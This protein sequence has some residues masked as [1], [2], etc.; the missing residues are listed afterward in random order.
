MNMEVQLA[1]DHPIGLR[2]KNPVM[3]ASGTFGFGNEYAK[4]LEVAK[5]GAIVTK[6]VTLRPRRGNAQPR[7]VET[8]AG[9]L[10][11]I[12]LQNPGAEAVIAQK[13]SMWARLDLPVIVNIAGETV[14]EYAELAEMFDS[15]AGV[16][17]LEV[18]VSCP[19]VKVGAMAFGV[20]PKAAAEVTSAVKAAT[21]MP[22]IVK[23]SPNVTDIVEI[24]QA[25]VEAGADAVSLINTLLG[26]VIDIRARR[27]LLSTVTGGLSGPAIRPVALRMVYQVAR[28]VAVPIIGV[29]GITSTEDALQFLMAGASAVQ[30][31]TATFV[32]PTT[33]TD[34]V[35]GLAAFLEAEGLSSIADIIG[36]AN[37]RPTPLP[38]DKR[39]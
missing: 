22:V 9:M 5:L 36:V 15:V 4:L 6:G 14:E 17:A 11:S 13:A 29:G 19:N 21:S 26:M 27:P 12:G 34:I 8:P 35:E 33:A 32:N 28:A 20:D 39:A 31:G 30:V 38:E 7:L 3:T 10:N 2:L 16:A 25:V 1:P 37:E 24:A 18:N 23:L